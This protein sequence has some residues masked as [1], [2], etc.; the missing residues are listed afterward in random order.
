M[1]LIN[2]IRCNY[3]IE[4]D[5]ISGEIILGGQ[6]RVINYKL[7]RYLRGISNSLYYSFMQNFKGMISLTTAHR[8][9]VAYEYS[10]TKVQGFGWLFTILAIFHVIQSIIENE[11]K[12]VRSLHLFVVG[13]GIHISTITK[14]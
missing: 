6:Q 4:K 1:Q 10:G 9:D 12:E 7:N 11:Y 8:E 5:A 3:N 13:F 14:T 2:Q